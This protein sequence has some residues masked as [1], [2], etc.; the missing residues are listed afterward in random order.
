MLARGVTQGGSL[1]PSSFEFTV[2]YPVAARQIGEL[3][4]YEPRV[5][6]EGFPPSKDVVPLV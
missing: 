4:V 6:E 2:E 5:T 3:D 1:E